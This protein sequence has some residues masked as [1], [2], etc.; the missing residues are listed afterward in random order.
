[1]S[2]LVAGMPA[3]DFTLDDCY[4][5]SFALS[6]YRGKNHVVLVFNRSLL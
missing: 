3:P 6:S 5:H 2:R 4:G 1:M